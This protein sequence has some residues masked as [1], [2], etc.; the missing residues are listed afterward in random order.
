MQRAK[1]ATEEPVPITF[2]FSRLG[3]NFLYDLG[4]FRQEKRHETF[5]C[6][7]TPTLTTDNRTKYTLKSQD[8]FLPFQ[9]VRESQS[10]SQGC[11]CLE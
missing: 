10:R 3:N 11:D 4:H 2:Q 6:F 8:V 1:A 7:L 9:Y 5:V